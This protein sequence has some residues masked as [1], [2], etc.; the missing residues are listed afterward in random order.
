MKALK[1]TLILAILLLVAVGSTF[2][3]KAN[4]GAGINITITPKTLIL[5]KDLGSVFCTQ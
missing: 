2:A 3:N 4:A 1:I 5:S